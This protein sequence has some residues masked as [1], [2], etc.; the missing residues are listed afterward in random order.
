M[1]RYT[2]DIVEVDDGFASITLLIPLGK[3]AIVSALTGEIYKRCSKEQIP[4]TVSSHEI[5]LHLKHV[6]GPRI[7]QEDVLYDV[8]VQPET[9][10][11]FAIC[12]PMPI[13]ESA[14]PVTSTQSNRIVLRVYIRTPATSK[15]P[16]DVL[17]KFNIKP[18]VFEH[19]GIVNEC[20][21]NF[22]RTLADAPGLTGSFLVVSSKST[23]KSL[24]AAVSTKFAIDGA[25]RA[26]FGVDIETTKRFCY[27]GVQDAF[28][29][30]AKMPVVSVCS[31]ERHI[32]THARV[33]ESA[34]DSSHARYSVV[35]LHT[36]EMP[37]HTSAMSAT[38]ADSGLFQLD[39]GH[40]L[41]MFVVHRTTTAVS[42]QRS[43]G[44]DAI[45]RDQA[46]WQPPVRQS[47]RG[48]AMFL[49]SLRVTASHVMDMDEDESAQDAV[50]HVFDVLV[51]F[52]PA[53]RT[54]YLLSMG[55]TPTTQECAA[56]SHAIFHTLDKI[57]PTE[58]A[59]FGK[60]RL[61]EGS[62]L[63]FGL[64]LERAKSVKLTTAGPQDFDAPSLTSLN[65]TELRDAQTQEHVM[66]AVSTQLGLIERGYY[67]VFAPGGLLFTSPAQ[68]NLQRRDSVDPLTARLAVLSGGTSREIDTFSKHQLLSKYDYEDGGVQDAIIDSTELTDLHYLAELCGQNK[69]AVHMP[70]QLVSAEHPCLTFD[71]NAHLAVYLGEEGCAQ[72]GK[73]SQVFRPQHE[74]STEDTAVIE[75]LI[76][77]IIKTYES[78]GT[79]VF[80]A[81]GGAAVRKLAAPDEIVVFCV[82]TSASMRKYTDFSEVNS[83]GTSS[84]VRSIAPAIEPEYYNG[85][86]FDEIKA[87]LS[88]Y[89]AIDDII[90]IVR[91][92]SG[93]GRRSRATVVLS[94]LGTALS[95]QLICKAEAL[96]R[97]RQRTHHFHRNGALAEQ[98]AAMDQL[99]RFRTGIQIHEQGLCDFLVYRAGVMPHAGKWKWAVGDAVPNAAGSAQFTV[100]PAMVTEIPNDIKCPISYGLMDDAFIAADGQIRSRDAL[101]KWF[102]VRRSSPL[103]GTPVSD[104]G[105]QE[106]ELTVDKATLWKLGKGL[107]VTLPTD[108]QPPLA[109]K[110]RMQ[111]DDQLLLFFD[112]NCGGFHRTVPGSL[113]LHDLYSLAFRGL[114]GRHSTFQLVLSPNTVLQPDETS[115]VAKGFTTNATI[116]IRITDGDDVTATGSNGGTTATR[117]ALVKVFQG[118]H[119]CKVAY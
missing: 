61:F 96:D 50:L 42:T 7:D 26:E 67:D 37:I 11:I 45:Y 74:T 18:A 91:T 113:S 35:D 19:T 75:Q 86:P 64:I 104:I 81:V 29:H 65:T 109:K 98:T 8:V 56:L 54:F 20:N 23:V 57:V 108:D 71:R 49:S 118:R 62:R 78:A 48:M 38:V 31:K 92:A 93:T 5:K 3:G 114:K 9:E 25:L 32:P 63:L 73:S 100:L 46:H 111:D 39:E 101:G 55:K 82:D 33:I 70:S 59:G 13:K 119:H 88:R 41:E 102:D 43:I 110:P 12:S 14:L 28:G 6:R 24:Q 117:L 84:D 16:I 72:P 77:P 60:D 10:N 99:K 1:P 21:C 112:S 69:L 68:P 116:I 30:F 85:I 97:A 115:L 40:G 94:L 79:D 47:N 76:A 83:D 27:H 107:I 36:S 52:P 87:T 53:L 105:T 90:A 4:V 15:D 51:G 22:A 95:N 103:H 2:V 106:H 17:P 89:E 34:D 58:L 66:H 80:D 44:N